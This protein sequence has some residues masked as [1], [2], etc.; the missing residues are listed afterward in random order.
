MEMQVTAQWEGKRR[1]TTTGPSGHT[2]TMDS[3][4]EDGGDDSGARPM[5]LLLMGLIGC[6]GIDVSLILERM[7]EP[8]EELNIEAVGMRREE[9]PQAYTNIHLIY[10]VKGDLEAKKI[11][12]AIRLSEEKYCSASASLVAPIT[13]ELILNG[14]SVPQQEV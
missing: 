3:K 5:E 10:K 6:T 4:R 7:R 11:W 12:R 1:F 2:I 13:T 14:V 9:K 8:L